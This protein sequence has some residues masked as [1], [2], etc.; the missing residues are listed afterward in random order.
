MGK[1]LNGLSEIRKPTRKALTKLTKG[2]FGGFVSESK[3]EYPEI[4]DLPESTNPTSSEL[5]KLTKLTTRGSTSSLPEGTDSRNLVQTEPAEEL[6]Q[7]IRQARDWSDLSSVLARAQAAFE[8]G[9][10]SRGQGEELAVLA[11]QQAH[12]LPEKVNQAD[13]AD[14]C[15]VWAEDLLYAWT[16]AEADTC[17]KCGQ[18]QW[19][20][21]AG[22]RICGVCHPAP[23][24]KAEYAT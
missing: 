21:K 11:A 19:W 5:T 13:N 9:E 23:R 4:N 17:L 24:R 22:R 20:D 12:S 7:A 8:R 1:W 3:Q 14:T 18:A 6:R 15:R 10:V 16:P 2:G